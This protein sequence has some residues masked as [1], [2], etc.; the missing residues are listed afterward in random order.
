M[1]YYK[2]G[3]FWND[4][5]LWK[6][7]STKNEVPVPVEDYLRS[8]L[9]WNMSDLQDAVRE[10]EAISLANLHYPIIISTDG[11]VLDGCHRLVKAAL[12][13]IEVIPAV[14]L[15]VEKDLPAPD[16]DE[17]EAVQK[18]KEKTHTNS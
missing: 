13:G 18:S 10:I 4:E 6:I 5:T 15:D 7:A 1:G 3:K 14:F 9:N 12:E 2:A 16:Y 11:L 17:W 8:D